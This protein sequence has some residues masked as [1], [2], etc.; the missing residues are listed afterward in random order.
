MNRGLGIS[1]EASELGWWLM[2]VLIDMLW[3]WSLL[4]RPL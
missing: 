4:V 2:Q 3:M 1:L